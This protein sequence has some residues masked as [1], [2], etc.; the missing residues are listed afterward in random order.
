MAI[1]VA[2]SFSFIG[3]VDM[4]VHSPLARGGGG[5]GGHSPAY[6]WGEGR[7]AR[8]GSAAHGGSTTLAPQMRRGSSSSMP[9]SDAKR[10]LVIVM[11]LC[12]QGVRGMHGGSA[13]PNA[14]LD[15]F[16]GPIRRAL[17]A[18]PPAHVRV[19]SLKW[20]L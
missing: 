17:P 8:G 3:L 10:S 7:S 11:E 14:M 20:P 4:P 6:P 9:A 5:G 12:D 18:W 1:M 15:D 19:T 13:R 16:F 2:K